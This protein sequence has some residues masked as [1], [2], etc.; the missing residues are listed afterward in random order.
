MLQY[1]FLFFVARVKNAAPGRSF[2]FVPARSIGQ[3]RGISVLRGL[4][5]HPARAT[6]TL[7]RVHFDPLPQVIWRVTC[8]TPA[9]YHGNLPAI[10]QRHNFRSLIERVRAASRGFNNIFSVSSP[11]STKPS[12]IFASDGCEGH[13]TMFHG[14][15]S[16]C[17]EHTYGSD[18]RR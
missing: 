11:E 18:D 15:P 2:K 16:G 14:L 12:G 10:H 4:T 1:V 3:A 13:V 17:I 5:R 6:A 8:R 9:P 7:R